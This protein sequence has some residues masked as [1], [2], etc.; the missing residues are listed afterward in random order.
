MFPGSPS[1]SGLAEAC[2]LLRWDALVRSYIG[3][4][5]L[6]LAEGRPRIS[7]EV[8]TLRTSFP[9]SSLNTLL[10]FQ[11]FTYVSPGQNLI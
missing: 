8:Y 1:A 10:Q 6:G 4:Q 7:S 2:G 9:I 5:Y 11:A 3:V